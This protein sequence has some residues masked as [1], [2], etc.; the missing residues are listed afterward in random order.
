VYAT[1]EAY[2]PEEN[3][4]LVN[5]YENLP[6]KDQRATEDWANI[7]NTLYSP[8]QNWDTN[9]N[10][11]NNLL[12]GRITLKCLSYASSTV[13]DWFNI[14][15]GVPSLDYKSIVHGTIESGTNPRYLEMIYHERAQNGI[16][17]YDFT[18]FYSLLYYKDPITKERVPY[19][20]KGYADILTNPKIDAI[21]WEDLK[22]N[23]PRE[24]NYTFLSESHNIG[25]YKQIG[26]DSEIFRDSDDEERLIKAIN[27]YGVLLTYTENPSS[28]LNIHSVAIVGFGVDETGYFFI[29]HDNYGHLDTADPDYP[30]ASKYKKLR[31]S[32]IDQA[33]A[34]SPKSDWAT[35]CHDQRRSCYSMIKSDIKSSSDTNN[36]HWIVIEGGDIDS[37]VMADIDKDNEDELFVTSVFFNDPEKDDDEYGYSYYL[38]FKGKEGS[39]N[40]FEQK[41]LVHTMEATYEPG[42]LNDL[43]SDGK[44][45]FAFITETGVVYALDAT[46][47]SYFWNK[48]IN[49]DY[50]DSSKAFGAI[51]V[52]DVDNNGTKEIIFADY[53]GDPD[54]QSYLYFVNAETGEEVFEPIEIGD[55]DSSTSGGT[56]YHLSIADLDGNGYPEIIVPNYY[57]VYIYEWEI[58]EKTEGGDYL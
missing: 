40:K 31:I 21:Q 1:G 57:G 26:I 58:I 55:K 20:L 47:G 35:F 51:S 17:L 7:I 23:N 49:N 11:F 53:T 3:D 25:S 15:Y 27:D 48:K 22:L 19:N 39:V 34:F 36:F 45:E 46:S 29:A 6:F 38:D 50:Q 24:F 30:S 14:N 5:L 33:F 16:D 54:E 52:A 12:T 4:T 9:F 37:I 8:Q 18:P 41:D 44:L 43:D 28:P 13:N 10:D 56:H 32:D 42:I 2:T